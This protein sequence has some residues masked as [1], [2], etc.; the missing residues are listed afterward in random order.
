MFCTPVLRSSIVALSTKPLNFL[1]S[2]P[3]S[4]PALNFLHAQ[5]L[6]SRFPRSI[7]KAVDERSP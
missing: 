7:G 3:D 2:R 6:L 5:G 1:K 4:K